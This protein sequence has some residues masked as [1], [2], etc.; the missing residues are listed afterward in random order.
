MN[1]ESIETFEEFQ[2]ETY[3]PEEENNGDPSMV[4][5]IV[6]DDLYIRKILKTSKLHVV[7]KKNAIEAFDNFGPSG[8]FHFFLPKHFFVIPFII[9]HFKKLVQP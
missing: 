2:G 8:L 6:K 3:Q 9:R 4:S 5:S 7:H 1:S